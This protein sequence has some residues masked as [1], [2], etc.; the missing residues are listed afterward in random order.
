MTDSSIETR[1]GESAFD[2][3]SSGEDFFGEPTDESLEDEHAGNIDDEPSADRASDGGGVTDQTAADVFDQLRESAENDADG[4]LEDESPEDII[5]S[6]D[7]PEPEP[8]IDEALSVDD[9][10]LATLLLTGRTKEDEFLWVETGE[11]TEQETES[12]S[13][14]QEEPDEDPTD[15]AV[16]VDTDDRDEDADESDEDVDEPAADGDADVDT[17]V[18]KPSDEAEKVPDETVDEETNLSETTTDADSSADD[19]SEPSGLFARLRAKLRSL[20]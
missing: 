18:E 13:D 9:D 16:D 1:S 5:A 3:N 11:A 2:L 7:D 14:T 19:E 4:V 15:T 6:A 8:E 12:E 20:F 10:E 17:D